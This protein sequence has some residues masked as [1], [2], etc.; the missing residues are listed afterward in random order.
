M[1][2]EAWTV[3]VE[4]YERASHEKLTAAID[5]HCYEVE[6]EPVSG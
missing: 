3:T 5:G 4:R 1:D 6:G 2:L